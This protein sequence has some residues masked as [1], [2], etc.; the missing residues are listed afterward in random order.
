MGIYIDD[1]LQG[2][3]NIHICFLFLVQKL[4]IGIQDLRK[5]K[6]KSYFIS[7]LKMENQSE[8]EIKLVDLNKRKCHELLFERAKRRLQKDEF[9]V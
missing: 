7:V 2:F 5:I 8:M 1:S 3:T 4:K 6:L 9:M